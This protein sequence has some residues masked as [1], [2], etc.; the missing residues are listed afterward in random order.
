M[1]QLFTVI[2]ML[3]L[4]IVLY[5]PLIGA[6]IAQQESGYGNTEVFENL[7]AGMSVLYILFVIVGVLVL[8]A[9]SVGLNAGFYRI[10]RK[11]D[12]DEQVLTSDFFYFYKRE[13]FN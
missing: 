11:L 9:I 12:H 3:P 13:V 5:I 6:V 8:G 7:F 10:M 4:I 1:L 2:V